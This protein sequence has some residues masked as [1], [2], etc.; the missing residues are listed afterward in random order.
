[1]N[2]FL[3]LQQKLMS[4]SLKASQLKTTKVPTGTIFEVK[5]PPSPAPNKYNPFVFDV[6]GKSGLFQSISFVKTGVPKQKGATPAPNKFDTR[7]SFES[8]KDEAAK[9]TMR[10]RGKL[11]TEAIVKS[12][13][14]N[15][16]P[17]SNQYN[18]QDKVRL[19]HINNRQSSMALG[20][21]QILKNED[22]LIKGMPGPNKYDVSRSHSARDETVK[23]SLRSR[24]EKKG[25]NTDPAPN[26][27]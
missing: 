19:L 10:G 9:F 6:V 25:K 5:R 21:N 2:I 12:A 27:Y 8:T 18:L 23:F 16:R 1:M 17:G 20:F 7:K 26:K 11:Y 4:Q 22:K 3:F 14:A 13:N 24:S 15:C